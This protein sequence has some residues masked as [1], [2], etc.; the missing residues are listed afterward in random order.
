MPR[1]LGRGKFGHAA[2]D[3][4]GRYV[5]FWPREDGSGKKGT[6][7]ER[8]ISWSDTYVEDVDHLGYSANHSVTLFHMMETSMSIAWDDVRTGRRGGF[9]LL[10]H[11]CSTV[12]MYLLEVGR[13]KDRESS[14]AAR[15]VMDVYEGLTGQTLAKRIKRA[16]VYEP[17]DVLDFAMDLRDR[18]YT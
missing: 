14:S 5:S 15:F 10:S 7:S 16:I 12:V 1:G 3:I 17:S 8:A 2:L 9:K 18:G 13:N 11:N 6:F 4:G